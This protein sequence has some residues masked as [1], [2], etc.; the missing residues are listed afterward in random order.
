MPVMMPEKKNDMA[1]IQGGV[2]G[3]VS[4][5]STA[6]PWGAAVGAGVGVLGADQQ[7]SPQAVQTQSA[8]DRR[9][10]QM[11]AKNMELQ[12]LQAAADAV[13]QLPPEQ[14]IQ[15]EPVINEALMKSQKQ[16]GVV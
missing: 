5:Y 10:E 2:S 12:Q 6:G 1:A 4:G 13:K 11:K 9:I 16:M 14:R 3:G 8:V 7:R 15:Y